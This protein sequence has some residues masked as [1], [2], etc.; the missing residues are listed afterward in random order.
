VITGTCVTPIAIAPGDRIRM[1]F[2]AL[3]RIEAA[4]SA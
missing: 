2:G 3:G 4:F 1:D